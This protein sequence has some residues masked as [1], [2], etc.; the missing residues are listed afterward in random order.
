MLRIYI[1]TALFILCMVHPMSGGENIYTWKDAQ[2][3]IH[4]TDQSPPDGVEIIDSS[5]APPK[6]DMK[7]TEKQPK[8][9]K[10]TRQ[11]V[12][13][14]EKLLKEF[15][16]YRAEEAAAWKKAEEL[17]AEAEELRSRSAI[18]KVKRK[19]RRRARALEEEAGEVI[20]KAEAAAVQ[21]EK[22]EKSL[23]INPGSK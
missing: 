21:A 9:G 17:I 4:I 13:Q 7:S 11:N 22:L 5:P 20:K 8:A 1:L 16:E 12:Q 2:G 14:R 3:E 23:N 19:Y 10:V 15:T 18:Q 6:P